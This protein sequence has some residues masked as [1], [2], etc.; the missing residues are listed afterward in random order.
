MAHERHLRD[1]PHESYDYS[2]YE[3][4]D[5]RWFEPLLARMGPNPPVL[6]IGS[7]LG[8]FVECC[9]SHRIPAVGIEL[10]RE[11]VAASGA[12]GIPVVRAD[13]SHPLPF[14][15]N[16]FGSALAHHVL[17]HVP[18]DLERA[19]LRE[20]R[21]VLRPGGFVFVV[22]PNI[23]HP[24]ARDDPDH[25]NLFTPH[26]L[27]REIREAGYRRVDLGTNYWFPFWEPRVRLGRIG[28][29]VSGAL[30]KVAPIDRWAAS[31]SALAWK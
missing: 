30:W 7:G 25:I 31:A 28:S 24:N 10:S 21:R 17:E 14:R 22:S 5:W 9:L 6:D 8:F 26:K 3:G 19:I 18:L 23:F 27:A 20:I 4:R 11:G 15:D 13:L 1:R 2:R 16:V 29:L 12:R